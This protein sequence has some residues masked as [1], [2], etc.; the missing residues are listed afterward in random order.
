VIRNVIEN[1]SV[2]MIYVGIYTNFQMSAALSIKKILT[3]Y[4]QHWKENIKF[5]LPLASSW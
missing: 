2:G 5:A 4:V 3:A 1:L